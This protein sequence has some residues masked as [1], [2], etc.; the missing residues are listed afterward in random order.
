MGATVPDCED[1]FADAVE[2]DVDAVHT[3]AKAFPSGSSSSEHAVVQSSMGSAD[4]N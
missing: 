3:H 2:Q 4:Y 1:V